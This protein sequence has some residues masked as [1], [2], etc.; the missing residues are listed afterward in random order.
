MEPDPPETVQQIGE[1]MNSAEGVAA[2]LVPLMMPVA[3][4][5]SEKLDMVHLSFSFGTFV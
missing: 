5:S 1:F 3:G 4:N 2:P